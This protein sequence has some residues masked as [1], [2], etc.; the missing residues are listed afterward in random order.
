MVLA[1]RERG[2]YVGSES[3]RISNIHTRKGVKHFQRH[4]I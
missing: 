2:L 1:G 4:L 3:M